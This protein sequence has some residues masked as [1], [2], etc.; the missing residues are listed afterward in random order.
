MKSGI[1]PVREQ[2]HILV[3]ACTEI[4]DSLVAIVCWEFY[5]YTDGYGIVPVQ[6][7][8]GE[9][10]IGAGLPSGQMQGFDGFSIEVGVLNSVHAF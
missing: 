5:P 6:D 9:L 3:L 1:P 7:P 4:P 8:V 2:I 10:Q